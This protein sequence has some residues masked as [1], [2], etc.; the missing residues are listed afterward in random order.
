[1]C[2]IKYASFLIPPLKYSFDL[3]YHESSIK[4]KIEMNYADS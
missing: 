3:S 1:M 2:I 4:D